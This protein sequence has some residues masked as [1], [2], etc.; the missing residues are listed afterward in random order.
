VFAEA[1][2]EVISAQLIEIY[3]FA[4]AMLAIYSV[5]AVGFETWAS[6]AETSWAKTKCFACYLSESTSTFK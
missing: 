3:I 4:I 6:V 5:C 2:F 1:Y